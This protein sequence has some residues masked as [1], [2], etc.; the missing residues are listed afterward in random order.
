MSAQSVK[1]IH[2]TEDHTYISV[3][4]MTPSHVVNTLLCCLRQHSPSTLFYQKFWRLIS[5]TPKARHTLEDKHG[6]DQRM[7]LKCALLCL[8][9]ARQSWVDPLSL[10]PRHDEIGEAAYASM[11]DLSLMDPHDEALVSPDPPSLSDLRVLA[12]GLK[13]SVFSL[14]LLDFINA[15]LDKSKY[16]YFVTSDELFSD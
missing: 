12:Q 11:I 9:D 2:L 15:M 14:H 4:D 8:Q 10:I 5:V 16:S 3:D 6:E 7:L 13:S 1:V